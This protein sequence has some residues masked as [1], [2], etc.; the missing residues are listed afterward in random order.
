MLTREQIKNM[1]AGPEMDA[2]IHTIVMGLDIMC[3]SGIDDPDVI[4]RV[5]CLHD[6][7]PRECSVLAKGLPY[8]KCAH[9]DRENISAY[10]T[11]VAVAMQV[12]DKLI[13]EGCLVT[14]QNL[15]PNTGIAAGFSAYVRGWPT[16]YHCPALAPKR[17]LAICRAALLWKL[18]QEQSK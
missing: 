6:T 9:A 11:D 17:P 10:S 1:D 7:D 8:W 4:S 3:Y 16:K 5:A 18:K 2:A 15:P 14:V 12:W 13:A